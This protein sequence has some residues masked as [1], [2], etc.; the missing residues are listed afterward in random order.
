MSAGRV[1]A[2]RY[3]LI[4]ELGHGGM[5]SVWRA[6]S[7]SYS[8]EVAVKLI[9][10]ELM[11]SQEALSRFRCEAEAAAAIRSTHV[12]QILDY[13]V[14]DDTPYLVMELLKGESLAKRL[15]RAYALTPSQTS[16]ILG[17]VARALSIAHKLGIVHRDMKPDNIFLVSEDD[18]EIAKVLDFG[19]AR[20]KSGMAGGGV[21]TQTG[22]LLGTPFYM[23]P[24]QA[25]AQGVDHLTD[26]WSFGIIAFQC[27]TGRRAFDGTSFLEVGTAICKDP[28]P[29]PSQVASV[30]DGFDEWF[31]HTAARPR[32]ER[33][34]T[35]KAAAEALS[36]VCA[37]PSMS[38]VANLGDTVVCTGPPAPVPGSNPSAGNGPTTVGPS[39]RSLPGVSA[40]VRRSKVML[41]LAALSVALVGAVFGVHIRKNAGTATASAPVVQ[42]PSS[43]R[44]TI[45]QPAPSALLETLETPTP[46]ALAEESV[47]SPRADA[48]HD[49]ISA[50]KSTRP[51]HAARASANHSNPQFGAASAAPGSP[52]R[53]ATP[54]P[55]KPASANPFSGID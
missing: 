40:P 37:R 55:N 4:E 8:A 3:E 38:S 36:A 53:A 13:G 6:R 30:P 41:T 54:P 44:D 34:Q 20:N 43:E 52:A 14:D 2:S 21:H 24:E 9:A 15:E 17:Q 1:L 18:D 28:M 7:L 42:A 25:T 12:V 45:T 19:I 11:A 46:S 35:I 51:N 49:P 48:G 5:G 31:S 29:V 33:F 47:V 50:E 39:S 16:S 23:S 26:I 22:T 10:P 32:N 27:L